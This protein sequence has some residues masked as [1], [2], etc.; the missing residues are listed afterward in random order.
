MNDHSAAQRELLAAWAAEERTQPDGWD[1]SSLDARMSESTEPWDLSA[2]WRTALASATRVL[3]MGTT[4][5]VGV[6]QHWRGGCEP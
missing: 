2:V 3:D 5:S 6:I 1:F 4:R